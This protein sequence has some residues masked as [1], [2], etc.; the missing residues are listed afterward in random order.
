MAS[1]DWAPTRTSNDV[2]GA[3]RG[4]CSEEPARAACPQHD[5]PCG[6]GLV[7]VARGPSAIQVVAGVYEFG[8]GRD[9]ER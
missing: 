1:E 4:G 6:D 3:F 9:L 8:A 5:H 2:D 7:A